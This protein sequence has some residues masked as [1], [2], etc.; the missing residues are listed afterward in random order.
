MKDFSN[1]V[2]SLSSGFLC[3]HARH[4]VSATNNA[5]TFPYTETFSNDEA[6]T[7]FVTMASVQPARENTVE[8]LAARLLALCIAWLVC[9]QYNIDR[10]WLLCKTKNLELPFCI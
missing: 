10:P 4:F 7:S 9:C 3:R 1:G 8:P 6:S 5:N 2:L